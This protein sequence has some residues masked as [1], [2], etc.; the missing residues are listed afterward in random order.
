[1]SA[2]ERWRDLV[3]TRLAES[4]SLRPDGGAL[5]P[6]FWDS[7]AKA[8]AR[9]VTPPRRPDPFLG[10]VRREV[11]RRSTVTDVGCGPGRFA[12][13][14]APRVAEVVALD[15]SG[16][17]TAITAGRARQAGLTNVRCVTGRWE[18]TPVPATDVAICSYVLP[19]APD[20]AAFLAKIDRTTRSRALVYM[21]AASVDLLLDP[22]WR[23]FHGRAR[24]PGPT[25][26]DAVAVLR[27]IGAR[28]RVEIVEVPT[29]GRYTT[30]AQAARAYLDTLVLADTAEVRGELRGVLAD[31]LVPDGDLLRPP[32]RSLPAAIV[33]WAPRR[34]PDGGLIS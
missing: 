8:F 21:G 24:C 28:P 18:D 19:L 12:L 4:A 25:Y 2:A 16:A 14:L 9:S 7:R 32:V 29:R 33:H 17:M 10:R 30:V 5:G 31:W 23:H 13:A 34:R 15:W 27:E 3:A 11:G 22:L 20:A 26:L 6:D 1:M